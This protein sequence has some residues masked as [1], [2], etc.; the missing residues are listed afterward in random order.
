MRG[1]PILLLLVALAAL[2]L[3]LPLSAEV[4]ALNQIA[5]RVEI[6]PIPTLTLSDQQFPT[7]DAAGTP[8][9]ISGEFRIAQGQGKLPVVVLMHGS[10]SVGP[11]IEPW[12]QRLNGMGISTFVIDGFTGCGLVST[13]TDQAR[14]GRL[15]F[16]LD[17][18]RT[19][20]ILAK[21]SRVDSS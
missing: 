7:G 16:I 11:N 18:Y 13:S 15:N 12:T 20:D 14:L 21:H 6:Y 4:P 9:T 2:P 8:V 10:G 19:L 3:P 1:T 17:I 5:Q